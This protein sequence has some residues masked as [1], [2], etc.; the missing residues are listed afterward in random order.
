M[1]IVDY[2]KHSMVIIN[3]VIFLVHIWVTVMIIMMITVEL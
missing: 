2:I 3:M 1:G